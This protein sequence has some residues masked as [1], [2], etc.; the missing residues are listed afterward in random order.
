MRIAVLSTIL[1]SGN[2]TLTAQ[3]TRRLLRRTTG[4]RHP[5]SRSKVQP[6]APEK[7]ESFEEKWLSFGKRRSVRDGAGC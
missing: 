7:K 5:R 6:P 1:L 3:T 2:A 4:G